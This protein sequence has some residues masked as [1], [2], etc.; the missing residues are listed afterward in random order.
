M[1]FNVDVVSRN[2]ISDWITTMIHLELMD[3]QMRV[4]IQGELISRWIRVMTDIL[5][6]EEAIS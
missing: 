1:S 5:D 3:I 2:Y 4:D 6:S